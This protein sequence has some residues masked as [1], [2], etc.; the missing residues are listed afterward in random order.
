MQGKI[1]DRQRYSIHDGPGIRTLIFLKGCPLNCAWCCN[2]ESISAN[3]EIMLLSQ[4]CAGTDKCGQCLKACKRGAVYVA[5]NAAGINRE[6]CDGCG[7]CARACPGSAMRNTEQTAAVEELADYAMKDAV[8][9][10]QS[11]GGVTLSGGEPLLQDVFCTELLRAFKQ[12]GLNTA[13]ETSAFCG[14]DELLA[15]APFAD[16][17]IV[18][19]KH[20][21]SGQHEK[22][23]GVGN[24]RILQNIKKLAEVNAKVEIR[25]PLIPG[26]NDSPENLKLTGEFAKHELGLNRITLL[27]YH[28]LGQ[29]KYEQLGKEYPLARIQPAAPQEEREYMESR[30]QVFSALGVSAVY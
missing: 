20:M 17:F 29:T 1:F 4:E 21:D 3:N 14:R 16:L 26:I 27:P 12:K 30:R 28:R 11:G 13:V 5:H 9:Y 19:I 18:D 25:V 6:A 24:E 8:F 7:D 15:A 10:K 22:Y 23:T 2:P